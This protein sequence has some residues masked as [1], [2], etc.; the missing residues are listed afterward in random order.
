MKK[1]DKWES[2]KIF[3]HF[4]M[5]SRK[6][7][8]SIF[9]VHKKTSTLQRLFDKPPAKAVF[10]AL[11]RQLDGLFFLVFFLFPPLAGSDGTCDVF[12]ARGGKNVFHRRTF[13][14][15]RSSC[16][17]FILSGGAFHQILNKKVTRECAAL[18]SFW[19]CFC[20]VTA[21]L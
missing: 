15:P 7:I 1:C 21:L 2:N 14:S 11:M 17:A 19:V 10:P 18:D 8:K 16:Q 12:I 20:Q 9:T 6:F 5:D 3:F 13:S 4:L